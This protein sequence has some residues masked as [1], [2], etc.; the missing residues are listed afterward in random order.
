MSVDL[1]GQEHQPTSNTITIET[2]PSQQHHHH[3]SN[4]TTQ[5][6]PAHELSN[7]ERFTP[8]AH[9]QSTKPAKPRPKWLLSST[10]N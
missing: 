7:R 4:T 3:T 10:K 5:I 1:V 6:Y 2:S 8:P 9:H